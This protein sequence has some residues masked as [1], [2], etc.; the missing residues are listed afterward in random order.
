M[1]AD[2]ILGVRDVAFDFVL[3][4]MMTTGPSLLR[5]KLGKVLHSDGVGAIGSSGSVWGGFFFRRRLVIGY[6]R[7]ICLSLRTL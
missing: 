7:C 4:W 6:L 3:A 2:W 5:R 1:N